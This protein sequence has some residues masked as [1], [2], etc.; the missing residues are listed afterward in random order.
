LP[1]TETPSPGGSDRNVGA[2]SGSG[3]KRH[4][5][6]THRA[7]E[8]G[9][10]E[11]LKELVQELSAEREGL[12]DQLLRALA[13][14]QNLRKRA[15]LER[16]ATQRFATESLIR[17]LLPVL[18]NFERTIAAMESGA[19]FE[20][21]VEGVKSVDRQLRSVLEGQALSRISAQGESFDP[22]VHE[23]VAAH[24]TREL[25]EG[26]VVEEL[27]PG[28]RIADT[29]IRPAKVRVSKRP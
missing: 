2:A 13:D 28:Y 16:A 12:R 26:T 1:K 7:T 3:A 9:E 29:V 27:E 10:L 4:P 6:D 15:Q 14:M 11:R 25:P 21:L 18:D 24:E 22:A 23:A 5:K 8:S 19:S 17:E 20:S